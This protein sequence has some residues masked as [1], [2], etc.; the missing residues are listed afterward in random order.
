MFYQFFISYI[1]Y[2]VCNDSPLNKPT[3]YVIYIDPIYNKTKTNIY[4]SCVLKKLNT[5]QPG[6]KISSITVIIAGMKPTGVHIINV[7]QS[8]FSVNLNNQDLLCKYFSCVLVKPEQYIPP[9]VD[10]FIPQKNPITIPKN[11]AV[12]LIIIT[13]YFIISILTNMITITK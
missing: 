3:K 6:N 5:P 10:P 12:N 13:L 8:S 9:I 4:L 7:V 1:L 11:N 2:F